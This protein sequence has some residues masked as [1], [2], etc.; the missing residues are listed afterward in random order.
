MRL[1]EMSNQPRA[2]KINKVVE[3]RFGFKIDYKN[4]TFKTAFNVVQG[5]NETLE[6]SKRT[7][8]AHRAEQDPKYMELFMVRESLKI[9]RAHV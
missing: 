1:S 2:E 7:H 6:R 4:L 5:I 9:G 3:S 8:G